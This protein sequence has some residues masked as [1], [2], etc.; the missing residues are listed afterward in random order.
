MTYEERLKECAKKHYEQWKMK[1][2]INT[3]FSSET[4]KKTAEG[5]ISA[6]AEGIKFGLHY[7]GC[8]DKTVDT[9]LFEEGYLKDLPE[10][11]HSPLV[12]EKDKRWYNA[13]CQKCKWHGSS[14]FLEGGEPIADTG[15]HNDVRCPYCGSSDI[16][17]YII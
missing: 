10:V 6:V 3:Y 7:M 17:D 16:D 1:P 11:P 2:I 14:E 13:E 4:F 12:D 15:D 8:D 5:T 9:V